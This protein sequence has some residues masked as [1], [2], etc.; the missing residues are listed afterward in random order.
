YICQSPGLSGVLRA[1]L[2]L[3]GKSLA[4]CLSRCSW[5]IAQW[6]VGPPQ[7]RRHV[8]S[9]AGSAEPLVPGQVAWRCRAAGE[10]CHPKGH[11]V[12]SYRMVGLGSGDLTPRS[13]VS[14]FRGRPRPPP[15][16]SAEPP[17]PCYGRRPGSA[18]RSPHR[19]RRLSSLALIRFFHSALP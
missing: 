8:A 10:W 2:V 7:Q 11:T 9:R 12:C 17:L 1:P 15:L 5:H 16:W 14:C 13:C 4:T 6:A 19:F 3:S 18:R